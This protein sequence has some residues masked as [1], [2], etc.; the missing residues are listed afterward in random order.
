MTGD[1]VWADD[2][3]LRLVAV[4]FQ[5]ILLHPRFQVAKAGCEGGVDGRGD[6]FGGEV[7][8]G[9]ISITVEAEA[10][11]PEDFTKGKDVEDEEERA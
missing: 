11:A 9:I 5:K 3:D 8:L 1:G 2:E 6:G 7:E 4:E 10:M